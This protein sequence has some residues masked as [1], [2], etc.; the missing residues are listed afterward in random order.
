MITVPFFD[1]IVRARC[2]KELWDHSFDC[3]KCQK[4][5]EREEEIKTVMI[6]FRKFIFQ[7]GGRVDFK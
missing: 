7:Y 4:I 5:F 3:K 6:H 1:F 2:G